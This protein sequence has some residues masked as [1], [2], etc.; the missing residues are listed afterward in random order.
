[1]W[2]ENKTKRYRVLQGCIQQLH[3][4]F[5]FLGCCLQSSAGFF[6]EVASQDLIEENSYT[7][8]LVEW[9]LVWGTIL[10]YFPCPEFTLQV[11]KKVS[12]VFSSKRR[13]A[14]V[15]ETV[16]LQ[17]ITDQEL[18]TGRQMSNSWFKHFYSYFRRSFP[19]YVLLLSIIFKDGTR[20]SYFVSALEKIYSRI[21]YI[22]V[23]VREG[24]EGKEREIELTTAFSSP[25]QLRTRY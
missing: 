12:L 20:P 4:C 16:P 7:L 6:I 10:L 13:I 5:A 1:M 19:K 21:A 14:D 11:R 3:T 24:G 9:V 15:G 2:R 18:S 17:P 22:L 25:M 23:L 8:A